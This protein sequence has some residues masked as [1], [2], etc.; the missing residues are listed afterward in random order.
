[1][2]LFLPPPESI[3]QT[4]ASP[5]GTIIAR[6]NWRK[7]VELRESEMRGD[8]NVGEEVEMVVVVLKDE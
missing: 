2:K 6:L 5:F 3:N 1:M 8:V 4:S 7:K